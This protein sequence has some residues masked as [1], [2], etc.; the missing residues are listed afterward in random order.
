MT[1]KRM[2]LEPPDGPRFPLRPS[3]VQEVANA[4]VDS[5]AITLTS[6]VTVGNIVVAFRACKNTT[7]PTVPDTS[8]GG[9]GGTAAWTLLGDVQAY[10]GG[11][12]HNI[13]LMCWAKVA[14]GGGQSQV[15]GTNGVASYCAEVANSGMGSLSTL[16]A[17]LQ[18]ASTNEDIGSLGTP[19]LNA[20]ALMM[21]IPD[22]ADTGSFTFT[23]SSGW[24][25][26]GQYTS[27]SFG[28]DRP[29]WMGHAVASG[30]ALEAKLTASLAGLGW[31]GIAL[32]FP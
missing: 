20:L 6:P 31:G 18:A 8:P 25:T 10:T 32:L 9:L 23:P 5:N 13:R 3:L 24:T 2:L 22:C 11:S 4:G 15:N 7:P 21:M 28:N 19:V 14:N 27:P 1:S 30:A 16:A 29:S 26:D 12:T 17:A